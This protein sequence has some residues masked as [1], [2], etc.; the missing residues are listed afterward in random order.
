MD[1]IKRLVATPVVALAIMSGL[2]AGAGRAGAAPAATRIAD[3]NGDGYA[4]LAV[5]VPGESVGSA[6]FAGSVNIV[7]GSA[8]G[9]SATAGHTDQNI[10]QDTLDVND[11]AEGYDQ[12]GTAVAAGD[13]NADG[14][15]DLAVGAAGEAI[16]GLGNA[17]AVNVIYGSSAGLRASAPVPDQLFRLGAG[18]VLGTLRANQYFGNTLATGDLDGDGY[19]D[20]A[21]G[22]PNYQVGSVVS[23]GSVEVLYGSASGLSTARAEL[24]NQETG[25]IFGSSGPNELYGL[26][27]AIADFDGD[28]FGDLA[29]GIPHKGLGAVNTGEVSLIY[30]SA[31]GLNDQRNQ[32]WYPG[33]N[34]AAGVLEAKDAF[35]Q[36]LAAG[37][38][39]GDGYADLAVGVPNQTVSG[40]T[41]A[42]EVEIL[43]GS[44]AG[45]VGAG[46]SLWNQDSPGIGGAAQTGAS[47]DFIPGFGNALEIADF[48]GDG[49]GD[50][51][52]ASPYYNVGTKVDAGAVNVLLGSQDSGL[53]ATGQQFWTQDTT[54][55]LGSAEKSDA[56]G[57]VLVAGNFGKSRQADL[58][59]A[60][61]FED[62]SSSKLDC[63]AANVLYGT[64]AGLAVSG[65]Q[66]FSQDSIDIGGTAEN[67]DSFGF[68][69]G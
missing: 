16:N 68:S 38:L 27:L 29:V 21:I 22:I 32:L 53:S 20:L 30:G 39:N 63:G 9:L 3:F 46:S 43:N 56:F 14:K 35:G 36:A 60:A 45:L 8:T 26:A 11:I 69:L 52:V 19:V 65:N 48:N 17:G 34:G 47:T 61:P 37:D 13:F 44:A 62:L 23:A 57:F 64:T 51:A 10:S 15:A 4:D 49:V 50:L 5:G 12:F 58:V 25:N 33:A 31:S 24:W 55:V 41:G 7:Y 6:L 2:V 42:G 1:S 40:K 67:G 66:L 59:V 28:G 54:G 18:G